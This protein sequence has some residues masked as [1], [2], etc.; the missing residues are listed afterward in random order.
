MSLVLFLPKQDVY[1]GR[2]ANSGEVRRVPQGDDDA[3]EPASQ[4]GPGAR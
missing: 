1:I 2:V 3:A 4:D